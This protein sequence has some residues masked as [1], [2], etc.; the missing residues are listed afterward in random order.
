M[1][2]YLIILSIFILNLLFLEIQLKIKKPKLIN[3]EL[4]RSLKIDLVRGFNL[5]SSRFYAKAFL[6]QNQTSKRTGSGLNGLVQPI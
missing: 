5:T 3:L 6:D 2:C 4:A 1:T